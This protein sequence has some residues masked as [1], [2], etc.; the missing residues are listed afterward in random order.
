M[1]LFRTLASLLLIASALAFA[2][3]KGK[4]EEAAPANATAP[5]LDS[6]GEV[7]AL[8]EKKQYEAAVE[9]LAKLREKVTTPSAE[10]EYTQLSREVMTQ[11]R[12]A[13]GS[14][15]SAKTAFRALSQMGA[16]R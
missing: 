7:M 16:G 2:G 11:L 4:Q 8:V 15:E 3:C 1:N 6:K 10:A 9:A 5:T 12:M 14:D 13:S